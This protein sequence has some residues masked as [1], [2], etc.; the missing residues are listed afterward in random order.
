MRKRVEILFE[1]RVR[2]GIYLLKREE[3]QMQKELRRA[4]GGG[5]IEKKHV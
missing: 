4:F 2:Y 5:A 3:I 1:N